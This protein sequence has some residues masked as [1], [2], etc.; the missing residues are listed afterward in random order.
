MLIKKSTPISWQEC[1][2]LGCDAWLAGEQAR[3][4]AMWQASL[5]VNPSNYLAHFNLG[6]W[7]LRQNLIDQARRH[8]VR[9]RHLKPDY[10]P[11]RV[12]L[13]TVYL[14]QGD[15]ARAAAEYRYVLTQDPHHTGA[16]RGIQLVERLAK[17]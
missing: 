17:R 11:G 10:L 12:N 6:T 15:P 3:A 9:V 2:Q 13:G 1:F 5:T 14:L 7:Y 8:L 4:L 16:Q